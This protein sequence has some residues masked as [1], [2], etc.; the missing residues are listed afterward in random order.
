MCTHTHLYDPTFT[1]SVDNYC[2]RI[3]VGVWYFIIPFCPSLPSLLYLSLSSISPS[4]PASLASSN[5]VRLAEHEGEIADLETKLERVSFQISLYTYICTLTVKWT[6]TISK[7][8]G[9]TLI[10]SLSIYTYIHVYTHIYVY[11][12]ILYTCI[13]YHSYSTLYHSI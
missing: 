8:Y 3:W 2:I 12:Y 9:P 11:M 4:L 7:E 6:Y 13:P 10:H 5:R 1:I